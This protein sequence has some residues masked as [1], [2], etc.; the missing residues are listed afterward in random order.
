M[1]LDI[2]YRSVVLTLVL[3]CG[4]KTA[5]SPQSFESA[6][7]DDAGEVCLE[8]DAEVAAPP[9]SLPPALPPA[10]PPAPSPAP[11]A[12]GDERPDEG[13]ACDDGNQS[14]G[15][16]CSAICQIE[17]GFICTP[18]FPGLPCAISRELPVPAAPSLRY[19]ASMAPGSELWIWDRPEGTDQFS[20]LLDGAAPA[21]YS[22]RTATRF[23]PRLSEG[24]H[25]LAVRACNR[26][27]RC[28][29]WVE[30]PTIVENRSVPHTRGLQGLGRELTRTALGRQVLVACDHCYGAK[31]QAVTLEQTSQTL[32]RAIASNGAEAV[33]L[34]VALIDGRLAVVARDGVALAEAPLLSDVLTL[35]VLADNTSLLVLELVELDTSEAFAKALLELLAAHP[36]L[37]RN[38]RPLLA[39]ARYARR[40]LLAE[41]AKQAAEDAVS[42]PYLRFVLG[43]DVQNVRGATLYEDNGA[44]R[45]DLAFVDAVSLEFSLP[46]LFSRIARARKAERGVFIEAVPGPHDGELVLSAL[47]EQVDGFFTRYNVAQARALV[48][49]TDLFA[50]VS[51]ADATT[52]SVTVY[53]VQ[54]GSKV[55]LRR[56]LGEAP[57]PAPTA[58]LYYPGSPALAMGNQSSAWYGAALDFADGRRLLRMLPQD[59]SAGVAR[60]FLLS[61]A[62][63][64]ASSSG[65]LLS[66]TRYQREPTSQLF[67]FHDVPGPFGSVCD[68]FRHPPS[69]RDHEIPF[70]GRSL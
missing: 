50:Y 7:L 6:C 25:K 20:V 41:L 22:D 62:G 37:A 15:D 24:N 8:Q 58:G 38:G 65:T 3:A 66:A 9:S 26:Q 4:G 43:D 64:F 60:G 56:A 63:V 30:G 59:P 39:Y 70:L 68:R 14:D 5:G 36:K 44:L 42:G 32:R 27:A 35:G 47:R 49:A 31:D 53:G 1:T 46:N 54:P 13:E 29:A 28:S 55:E 48:S 52:G 33:K 12:C 23:A 45:P 40:Q 18:Y 61:V 21:A 16:G 11:P 69:L 51:A 34:P 57:R 19:A 10:P 2:R 67:L 17:P